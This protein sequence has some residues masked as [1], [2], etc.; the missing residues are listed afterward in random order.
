MKNPRLIIAIITNLLDEAI[1]VAFVIF[2]LPRLGVNIPTWGLILIG[3]GFLVYAVG[4]YTIGSRALNKKPLPGLTNMV[5]VEGRAVSRLAPEGFVRI[6]GE[7]WASRADTGTI[8]S[9]TEV[10]VVQQNRL[11]LTV[12]RKITA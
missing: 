9:G 3:V 7:L 10:L 5:G 8:E 6:E 12:R 2:G 4:F 1:I 11:K